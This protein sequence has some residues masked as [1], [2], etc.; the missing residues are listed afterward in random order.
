MMDYLWSRFQQIP[1]IFRGER[2]KNPPKRAHFM[3]PALPRKHLKLYNFGTT[4][5]ILMKRARIMYYHGNFHLK[6]IE[7][8]I[9]GR[10][11]AWSKNLWKKPKNCFFGLISWNFQDYI[12]NHIICKSLLCTAS[13]VKILYTSDIIWGSYTQKT[14]Q[15][16]PKILFSGPTK[17]FEN[18]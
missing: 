15:K 17:T 1:A 13:L 18:L 7:A 8:G 10:K 5:A 11:R 9:I 4:N 12:K 6:K 14:T 16:Q 3:A 2:P